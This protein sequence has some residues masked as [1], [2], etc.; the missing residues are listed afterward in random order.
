MNTLIRG[1]TP[2]EYLHLHGFLPAPAV[3]RLLDQVS[4]FEKLQN[5]CAQIEF[6][7]DELAQNSSSEVIASAAYEIIELSARVPQ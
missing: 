4:R 1:L 5:A 6:E 7:L 3:E 2:S